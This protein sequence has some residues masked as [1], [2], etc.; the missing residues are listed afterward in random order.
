MT[1][2]KPTTN[3]P[4]RGN[5]DDEGYGAVRGRNLIWCGDVGDKLC[6]FLWSH[7][8]TASSKIDIDGGTAKEGRKLILNSWGGY[9]TSMSSI[10][11]LFEE[12]DNLTTVATGS[13]MSA[14][15]PIVAAGT[16]GQRYAT[17]RTR[18]MLHPQSVSFEKS[19]ELEDL[20]A[21]KAECEVGEDLYIAIMSRYC[22]HTKRW[23]KESLSR[24]KPWYF[25]AAEAQSL[26]IIDYV[27]PDA[28]SDIPRKR[29]KKGK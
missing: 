22:S 15:V 4:C 20:D 3:V 21:E 24:H 28:F 13:C 23:W 29:I 17:W 5:D 19:L 2:Y 27:I 25:S 8:L 16:R 18:F 14:A 11:D 1:L 7:L 12:V 6:T 9:I 10:V 26:G